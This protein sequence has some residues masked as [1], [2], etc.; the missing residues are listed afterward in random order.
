MSAIRNI[1]QEAK[2][3]S[4]MFPDVDH[5]VIIELLKECRSVD[6]AIE[7]ILKGTESAK[8]RRSQKNQKKSV[9]IASHPTESISSQSNIN[10]NSF[11][12][13][14]SISHHAN[15][16][17]SDNSP[18]YVQS[19]DKSNFNI[20]K[21]IS[22]NSN[23]TIQNISYNNYD[24]SIN[25]V[26]NDTFNNQ[27]PQSGSNIQI[28]QQ[29]QSAQSDLN[30]D[31]FT[32]VIN[33]P[34]TILQNEYHNAKKSQSS[35]IPH[36]TPYSF[37]SV[38]SSSSQNQ[39]NESREINNDIIL[40]LPKDLQNIKP[41]ISRFGSFAGPVNISSHNTNLSINYSSSSSTSSLNLYTSPPSSYNSASTKISLSSEEN[42]FES[43]Q[44]IITKDVTTQLNT[45]DD[46][47]NGSIGGIGYGI[48][49]LNDLNSRDNKSSVG[50][51]G[52]TVHQVKYRNLQFPGYSQYQMQYSP[53]QVQQQAQQIQQIQ[54]Q[55]QFQLQQQ[56]LYQ[57][58]QQNIIMQMQLPNFQT[59]NPQQSQ[60]QQSQQQI[61]LP[62]Y[63]PPDPKFMQ[64]Q[65]QM[66]SQ[67]NL[68]MPQ[69]IS[70]ENVVENK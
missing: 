57:Q 49:S 36:P 24:N 12:S 6:D 43:F 47:N 60:Q 15:I 63:M 13:N 69:Q 39:K 38:V 20:S 67:Y 45:Y 52:E 51:N 28:V 65:Q 66:V 31:S 33:A 26:R 27:I 25:T 11:S 30:E 18:K 46:Q 50:P 42:K 9:Q 22:Q 23:N 55:Q 44:P 40:T 29:K 70:Q 16:I 2:Q 37:D 53:F 10:S 56:K 68:H 3:V 32:S 17:E 48:E 58:Q 1:N 62:Q 59:F 41:N 21:N 7:Q 5:L 14:N 34:S 64:T 8:W 4:E 19:S 35:I 61:F 54:Q